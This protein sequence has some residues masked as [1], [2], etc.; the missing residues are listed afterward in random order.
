MA[1]FIE[2]H[3]FAMLLLLLLSTPAGAGIVVNYDFEDATGLF[4]AVPGF[5]LSPLSA[6]AWSDQDNTLTSF[7]GV[8][9]RAAAAKNWQD[10]NAFIFSITIPATHSLGL[11]RFD[12]DEKASAT[13]PGNWQ[14]DIAGIRMASATTSTSFQHQ[15]G[16]LAPTTL[17]GTIPIHLRANG[18]TSSSGTWRVDNFSLQG[19]LSSVPLPAAWVLLFS[20]LLLLGRQPRRRPSH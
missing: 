7:S 20:A 18:A 8:S 6:D 13:G 11:N 9:G 3:K 1:P 19:Q 10:G 17:T 5:V 4:T 15:G 2:I 12:F 14:L 16:T